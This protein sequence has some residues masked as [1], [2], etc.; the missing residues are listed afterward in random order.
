[1]KHLS[2]A[3]PA[4]VG[5]GRP[6]PHLAAAAMVAGPW[7]AQ[8]AL[9]RSVSELSWLALAACLILAGLAALERLQP[10]GRAAEASQATLLLGML[11]MLSGLTLDARGP[12]LDLMT[13]LCG[14]GGLDDFLFASYLH[15]S[16]L[17]AMHA[18]MLAGGSAALPLA[19]I[20]RRR[21]HSSWQT[22][23]LRHAACSGWMLAG[24]TF[25]VLAC[26]RAAAW[27]PAGAAPGTGPA[28]MLGGM[29]AGM[30]WGMVASAVFNRAC[31]RLARV[32]I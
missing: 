19:R 5:D 12:G 30:V 31:S 17:P 1:M 10:A 24:M 3:K 32:A 26:Q 6:H 21:A 9:L 23:I 18:G 27:F 8:V 29:F 16:W 22:D 28:S 7:A 14:A 25:G 2:L 15:W 20:T 4:M 11:G 13:S